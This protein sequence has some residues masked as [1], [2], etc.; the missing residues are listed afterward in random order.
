VIFERLNRSFSGVDAMVGW[1]DE[2][3]SAIGFLEILLDGRCCL[4]IGHVECWLMSFLG[5]LSE[6]GI[7][8]LYNGCILNIFDGVR[9]DVI[10]IIIIGDKK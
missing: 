2:L 3:P 6:Y 8:S 4:I 1:F 5:E 10:G 9:K 7:E